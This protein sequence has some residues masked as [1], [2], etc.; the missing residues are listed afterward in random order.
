MRSCNELC[1][2]FWIKEWNIIGSKTPHILTNWEPYFVVYFQITLVSQRHSSV[3]VEKHAHFML[4]SSPS[5]HA[6]ATQDASV[7][8]QLLSSPL[9]KWNLP[10]PCKLGRE[11]RCV[12]QI[13]TGFFPTSEL[14]FTRGFMNELMTDWWWIVINNIL[15]LPESILDYSFKSSWSV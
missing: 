14:S 8:L 6:C 1:N 5:A 9:T 12:P 3:L 4:M 15:P 13:G 2:Y 11:T 7:W 10:V